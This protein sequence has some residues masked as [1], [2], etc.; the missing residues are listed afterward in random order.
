MVLFLRPAIHAALALK[1]LLTCRMLFV[2]N[3]TKLV[4][5][6]VTSL[7]GKYLQLIIWPRS[8]RFVLVRRFYFIDTRLRGKERFKHSSQLTY[9]LAKL[10]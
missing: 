5:T 7:S 4:Q 9:L 3:K 2:K 1:E 6:R 10:A 8:L